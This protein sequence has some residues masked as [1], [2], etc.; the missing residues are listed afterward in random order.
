SAPKLAPPSSTTLKKIAKIYTAHG[1]LTFPVKIWGD[2]LEEQADGTKK[3]KKGCRFPDSWNTLS[4]EEMKA[5]P[6]YGRNALGILTGQRSGIT[7]VEVDNL[8]T[9]KELLESEDESEPETVRARS[10]NGG[11][12]LYFKYVPEFPTGSNFLPGID[13]R[14]DKNGCIFAPPSAFVWEG[15]KREYTW[16]PGFSLIDNADKLM[17]IPD[18]LLNSLCEAVAEK[19]NKKSKNRGPPA[20]KRLKME[21]ADDDEDSFE[22]EAREVD[23]DED[24]ESTMMKLRDPIKPSDVRMYTRKLAA[25]RADDYSLWRDVG[26]AVHH[27]TGG[28]AQG[29]QIFDEFSQ[30]NQLKYDKR[31]VAN[32]WRCIKDESDQPLTFGSL[33]AWVKDDNPEMPKD[34]ISEKTMAMVGKNLFKTFD[35]LK[36]T[37]EDI[38]FCRVQVKEKRLSG[39][40][41][42][43]GI[44]NND[45]KCPACGN[46]AHDGNVYHVEEPF[47]DLLVVRKPPEPTPLRADQQVQDLRERPQKGV[48]PHRETWSP[49]GHRR[50]PGL[51]HVQGV[52]CFRSG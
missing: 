20:Y 25:R 30:R 29:L 1:Y 40:D 38:G 48:G 35:Q 9:W 3:L 24:H 23:T 36:S 39:Y 16:Y 34:V 6:F 26:F 2:H 28:S 14:N 46:H 7:V 37:L 5:L 11:I 47:Q 32:F 33:R 51:P 43:A 12:H 27:A 50:R 49:Q 13:I 42:V 15:E 41:F 19:N 21:D 45:G 44:F 17:Q 4:T 22:V 31:S 10:Q 52:P 18:W 8:E